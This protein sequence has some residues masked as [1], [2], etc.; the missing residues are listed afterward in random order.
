M[1]QNSYHK[2]KEFQKK[3]NI[4]VN[5]IFWFIVVLLVLLYLF[6][7]NKITTTGNTKA[8]QKL[9]DQKPESRPQS[10]E[11]DFNK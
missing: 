9:E 2:K 1:S 3:T 4:K 10:G 6:N 11:L 8:D 5:Y 7:T